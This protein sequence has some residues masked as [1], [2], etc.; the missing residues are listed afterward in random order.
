MLATEE[1]PLGTKPLGR[2]LF[3]LAVPTVVANIVN[4]LYNIVDQIFIGQGVGTLG[5]AATSVAFPLTTICLA[6]G[7]MLGLG[8][9]A[10][11]NLEL[12]QANAAGAN[13]ALRHGHE[14]RAK[15]IV[16]SSVGAMVVAGVI[17]LILVRIFLMP[18][19]RVFGATDTILP[20]AAEYAGITSWGIPF[21]LF[22][23]GTNPIV[24][25]DRSPR[26]SMVA[27]ITGAVANIILDPVFI[28][29]F[30]W[31]IA[32]AA[33]ATVISQVMSALI[34]GAYFPRFRSV[35]LELRDF[36]PRPQYVLH[37]CKLGINSLIFQSS[38]LLV[39]ITMNNVLRLYG[40][41]T[42]Y[43][44]DIP[45][46]VCGIVMKI[47][48]IFIALMIGLISGAQPICS[49][50]Y[51]AGRYSRV[52]HTVK[53]FTIWALI[54]G[55]FSWSLFQLF[56]D[57]IFLLFGKAG[58]DELY[59]EYAER[60]MRTFLFFTFLNG[61]QICSATF[62]PAI[63]KPVRGAFL[64]FS[65]QI[66]IFMPLVLILPEF[67]GL[68]GVM[69]AQPVTDLLAFIMAASFLAYE[70][71]IMPKEDVRVR[72]EH[73]PAAEGDTDEPAVNG[74]LTDT[75]EPAVNGRLAD[76]DEPAV[77]GRL[78]DADEPKEDVHH[79]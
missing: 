69:Y 30:N 51:G 71:H 44:S 2:L 66:L 12:G 68:D 37:T 73:D 52:R 36:I 57:K 34:L 45:I 24:R 59:F 13:A 19:L 55:T 39:Q 48:V 9:A 27:I 53:L 61:V 32:G 7:L 20:Y 31:G 76:A 42:V 74:C 58:G 33:W 25:A 4:A 16:G 38:T 11:F 78:T 10:G 77:N 3:S 67:Y 46:A 62:F 17:I 41:N 35:R 64:S 22:T 56:P 23:M 54:I 47:N 65:K 60:F 43:G 72:Y 28:F 70:M 18:M 15:L 29:V 75:D 40:E 50:N 26:Y 5:N 8:A 6:L 21:F 63:G 14:E 1:N 49:Y 79:E